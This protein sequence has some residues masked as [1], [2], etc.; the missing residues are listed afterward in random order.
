[1]REIN[2]NRTGSS[3]RVC[4]GVAI[5]LEVRGCV[6]PCVCP[7]GWPRWMAPMDGSDW[8]APMDGPGGWPRLGCVSPRAVTTIG[9]PCRVSPLCVPKS[10]IHLDVPA[11]CPGRM[12]PRTGNPQCVP[13]GWPRPGCVSPRTVSPVG[14][15]RELATRSESL[16]TVPVEC[17]HL[18]SRFGLP[19]GFCLVAVPVGW[20]RLGCGTCVRT[21]CPV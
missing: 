18:V 21:C 20:P 8:M 4:A 5:A 11:G 9:G 15:L 17:P 6:W 19:P 12:V 7:D 3:D 1:M 13:G 14:W 10:C 16:L 2:G